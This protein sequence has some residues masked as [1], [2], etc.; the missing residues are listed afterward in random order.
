MAVIWEFSQLRTSS[1]LEYEIEAEYRTQLVAVGPGHINFLFSY[2][3]KIVSLELHSNTHLMGGDIWDSVH[4]EKKR[5]SAEII[6]ASK[7]Q[8]FE[9][10]G[11]ARDTGCSRLRL[12]CPHRFV[13]PQRIIQV[14]QVVHNCKDAHCSVSKD[15]A[16]KSTYIKHSNF[17]CYIW[18][19]FQL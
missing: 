11:A 18:N 5:R 17:N 1:T 15:G 8:I 12:T 16:Q 4:F 10:F 2:C 6:K 13:L 7:A 14:K 9:K 19:K 3:C